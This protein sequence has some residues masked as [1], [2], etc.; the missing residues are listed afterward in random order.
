MK[1][2]TICIASCFLLYWVLIYSFI[3]TMQTLFNYGR[4]IR[5]FEN[6]SPQTVF[7]D[8]ETYPAFFDRHLKHEARRIKVLCND[9]NANIR[10]FYF[11]YLIL[12]FEIDNP[13]FEFYIGKLNKFILDP[14]FVF[15]FLEEDD[16][17][18]FNDK[19]F[20]RFLL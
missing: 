13:N 16:E 9:P 3:A 15:L 1:I 12:C 4:S 2:A 11:Q 18:I 7:L 6:N 20:K 5:E 8:A 10:A 14:S 19:Q 17:N